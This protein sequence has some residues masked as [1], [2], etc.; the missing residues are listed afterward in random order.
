[1]RYMN[2]WDIQEAVQRYSDHP[3]LGKATR[4][5]V[6]FRDEVNSHSDGWAYWRQPVNAAAKLMA[7]FDEPDAVTEK[8]FTRALG[9][10]RS[11]MTRRGIA[12]GMTMPH[13]D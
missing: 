5:L 2:E 4:F 6:D 12:A 3:V 1:M 13:V 7:L 8:D 9:P 10:I 11:F